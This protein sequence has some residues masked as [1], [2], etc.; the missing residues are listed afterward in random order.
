[1]LEG[2]EYKY[3]VDEETLWASQDYYKSNL[4]E[5][6]EDHAFT[7][8]SGGSFAFKLVSADRLIEAQIML[9]KI[10][11]SSKRIH[12]PDHKQTKSIE[13]FHTAR[14]VPDYPIIPPLNSSLA[15]LKEHRFGNIVSTPFLEIV[16]CPTHDA[17]KHKLHRRLVELTNIFIFSLK[18][19][20]KI[21]APFQAIMKRKGGR[22]PVH[23]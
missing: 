20:L 12:G 9:T 2:I 3:Q 7:I 11:A 19:F 14:T 18:I 8:S 21:V 13:P 4:A 10:F 22:R 17:V 5:Y 16:H 1:M 23:C 6:G 15:S